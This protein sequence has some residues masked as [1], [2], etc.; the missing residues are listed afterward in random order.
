MV[1]EERS[2]S[3]SI[4]EFGMINGLHGG[5]SLHRY[6]Y[7]DCGPAG[8]VQRLVK[9]DGD[10]RGE[11]SPCPKGST[12]VRRRWRPGGS[13]GDD[14]GYLVT[15]T[16]DMVEDPTRL[17]Y[18]MRRVC[19]GPIARVTLP[20]QGY[21][22]ETKLPGMLKQRVRSSNGSLG[23]GRWDRRS[24]SRTGVAQA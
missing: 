21:P 6:A 2:S 19:D 17:W 18:L 1:K 7:G 8:S 14:D 13:S 24:G 23:R 9:H 5:A 22:F 15:F 4:T 3:D 11:I 20:E 12:A 10:R 16:I